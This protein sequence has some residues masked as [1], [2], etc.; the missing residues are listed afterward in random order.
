MRRPPRPAHRARRCPV[1]TG[2]PGVTNSA[3]RPEDRV[4]DSASIEVLQKAGRDGISTSF[5]RLDEQ[6]IQ[7]QFG[8]S[9]VCCRICHMG[10]CRITKKAPRGVCGADADTIVARNF[11]RELVGGAAA[12][13]DHARHLVLLLRKV[14]AGEGGDYR[15]RDERALRSTARLYGVDEAGRGPEEIAR[16]LAGVLLEE[17]TK[18][19]DE[20]A[21]VGLAPEN[22]RA[23]WRANEVAPAGID[24]MVV[25]SM[26]RT[27]MGVDHDYRS[28]LRQAF[29]TSVADGWG[30]SRIASMV[31]DI[32][33]GSP[34]PVRST[35]NLGVLGMNTVNIIVHGHEP[36]L[37]E[38]L[39]VA[40]RDPEIVEHARDVGA[41]GVTLAGICCTANEIL[42]RHG[43]PVAGNFLQQELAL[44]TGA[45]EM[46][47]ID[48]QCCMPSLPEVAAAY[49]TEIVSTSA[50]ARTRGASHAPFDERDALA[51]AKKLITRA[52]AN[53]PRR[54][55]GKVAIPSAQKPLVAGFSVDAIKYMLG[56]SFRASFRPLN[57]AIMQ[58]RIVGIAGIV[59]CNNPKTKLD[60]YIN[61]L[62]RELVKRNVLVLKTGCAAIASAKEG[63]LT[64]EAAL[65]HA[66]DG[67]REVCETVG[68]PPILHLGSCVDNSRILEAATE[69]VREGGLG[70]DISQVPAVGVAP[71][72]MSEKAVAIG[73]YFVASGIDVILGH[74][75]HVS[76]SDNVTSFLNEEA[77]DLF[78]GSFH[79]AREPLEAAEKIMALLME[80]R[81]RLGI[82]AKAERK[83]YDMKDRRELRV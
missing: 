78:G 49:H 67:L 53:Y 69:V 62:T 15:L 18:Q 41:E 37:S 35:A 52:I 72:W 9:G 8:K 7:C 29:R 54:D 43:I 55:S 2:A 24:R 26:H 70:D 16:E 51:S 39:A 33:F 65:A 44:V 38:M 48:V 23:I 4:T 28:V 40:S 27:H 80:A 81:E 46:M 11:L 22:Q 47:L 61:T 30:G 79:V 10:P 56:G 58:N 68:M 50:I 3:K 32:L 76:G 31:S 17:F 34:S 82:N 60:S 21:T 83:L 1:R 13:S 12:H 5:S 57:D 64:P 36:E 73:C 74:P 71:E 59:G 14:A 20:L 6:G 63:L 45:V 75:F 25:E 66:G 19:E 77:R 42:M